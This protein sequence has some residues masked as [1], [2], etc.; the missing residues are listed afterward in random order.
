MAEKVE[1]STY[2]RV[3]DLEDSIYFKHENNWWER[4]NLTVDKLLVMCSG[5]RNPETWGG[6]PVCLI[7]KPDPIPKSRT[8]TNPDITQPILNFTL[9]IPENPRGASP[10]CGSLNLTWTRKADPEPDPT[11][12]FAPRIHHYKLYDAIIS[13]ITKNCDK[14]L[15]EWWPKW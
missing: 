8:Q 1:N 7:P 3:G 6:C 12:T 9:K 15:F 14:S 11:L 5:P 13:S 2:N 4:R 10:K